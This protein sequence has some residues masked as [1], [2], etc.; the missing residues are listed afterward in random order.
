MMLRIRIHEI[1]YI[2]ISHFHLFLEPYDVFCY[3]ED[4]NTFIGKFINLIL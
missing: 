3:S 4:L 1:S 2:Y